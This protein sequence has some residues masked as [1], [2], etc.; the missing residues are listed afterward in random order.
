MKLLDLLE[1][2][3][4]WTIDAE[5]QMRGVEEYRRHFEAHAQPGDRGPE[6]EARPSVD[7]GTVTVIEVDVAGLERG[8][9]GVLIPPS[10]R[11]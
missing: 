6:V 4:G 2:Y 7:L 10:R 11:S 5:G 1:M 8:R 9:I 3:P